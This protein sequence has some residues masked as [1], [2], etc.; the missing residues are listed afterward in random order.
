MSGNRIRGVVPPLLCHIGDVN[1]NCDK[2][3][4]PSG[5]YNARGSHHEEDGKEEPCLPCF[6]GAPYIGQT[7]CVRTRD[8]HGIIGEIEIG[9]EVVIK[10]A[11]S[12]D[13]H[14][15]LGLG[16]AFTLVGCV[17]LLGCVLRRGH[18]WNQRQRKDNAAKKLRC[19]LAKPKHNKYRDFVNC[20]EEN[21][22]STIVDPHDCTGSDSSSTSNNDGADDDEA[23]WWAIQRYGEDHAVV[24]SLRTF[25]AHHE[26]GVY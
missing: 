9:S 4:C 19:V 20:D 25:N 6:D 1:G 2:I 15:K 7:S 17:F 14:T 24:R 26:E 3:A 13:E 10:S 11:E 8:P 23:L 18:Q 16:I 5:T 21:I 22:A 12:L